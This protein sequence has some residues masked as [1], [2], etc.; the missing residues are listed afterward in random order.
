MP[1][2]SL[3][4]RTEGDP[5]LA[6]ILVDPAEE[7]R[8]LEMHALAE[9]DVR[10]QPEMHPLIV[11]IPIPPEDG[12]V[13]WRT[14]LTQLKL[15][16]S[17]STFNKKKYETRINRGGLHLDQFTDLLRGPNTNQSQIFCDWGRPSHL[18]EKKSETWTVINLS[19]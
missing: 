6:E 18:L 10:D 15:G 5:F 3:F 8:L 9:F 12:C 19:I 16:Q 2:Q 7:L 13:L 4:N 17:L 14:I 1:G 11:P